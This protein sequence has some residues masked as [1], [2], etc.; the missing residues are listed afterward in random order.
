[1]NVQT[2]EGESSKSSVSSL[3][4]AFIDPR[5]KMTSSSVNTLKSVFNKNHE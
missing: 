1:M 4:D 2:G 5:L 3:E